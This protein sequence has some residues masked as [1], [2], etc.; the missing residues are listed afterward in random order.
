MADPQDPA[1]NPAQNAADQASS[2]AA[3]PAAEPNEPHAPADPGDESGQPAVGTPGNENGAQVPS[4]GQ[5]AQ[6]RQERRNAE[7]ESRIRELTRQVK[8]GQQPNQPPAGFQ[9]SPQP[10]DVRQYADDE[11]N[12]DINATNQ[13][14]QA[15]VVQTADAIATARVNQQLQQRDAVNN[16]ERDQETLP[17]KYD[18]LN[19]NSDLYTEDLDAVIAQEYQERAFRTVGYDPQGNPIKA[20]DGSV[21]LADI[22]ERHVKGARALA[23]KMNARTNKA[24][25]TVA[26][27]AAARPTGAVPQEREFTSLSLAEMKAKVG[28]HKT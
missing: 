24:V 10:F 20:L 14:F 28:Y 18:E 22:A 1:Q 23:E 2:P 8:Q 6:S 17:S 11:G 26:D 4:D 21:R 5:P 3:P 7:R 13:A 15:N 12:L 27:E 19:P 9:Q 25:D 16:F